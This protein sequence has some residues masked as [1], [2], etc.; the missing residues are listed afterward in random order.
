MVEMAS[1]SL[2]HLTLRHILDISATGLVSCHAK[3]QEELV[4]AASDLLLAMAV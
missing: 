4:D 1:L 3:D 2:L